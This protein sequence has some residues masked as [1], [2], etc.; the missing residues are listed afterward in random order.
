MAVFRFLAAV[1]LLAATIAL[2]S[3]ATPA[4]YGAG[5]FTA[6]SLAGHWADM[7]PSSLEAAKKAVTGFAPVLWSG[8]VGPVLALPTFVLFGLLALGSG[9]LGRRRRAVRIFVN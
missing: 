7:A 4:V 6:T 1:F 5:E 9:F 2:V 8:V 3:D